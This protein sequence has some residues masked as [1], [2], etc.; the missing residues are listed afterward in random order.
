MKSIV[1]TMSEEEKEVLRAELGHKDGITDVPAFV[2]IGGAA[3]MTKAT[4][5]A[6]VGPKL[7]ILLLIKILSAAA[8]SY[9][10]SLSL[11]VIR[12]HLDSVATLARDYATGGAPFE[13]MP[14][15]FD[16]LGGGDIMAR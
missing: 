1:E 4:Q 16:S 9:D 5:N 10:K 3:F 7:G 6:S 11:K 15:A 14:F 8:R 2:P 13:E 12:L